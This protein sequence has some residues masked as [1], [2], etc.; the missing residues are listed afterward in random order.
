MVTSTKGR[1]PKTPPSKG[2][3]E[4]WKS[5]RKKNPTKEKVTKHERGG[6]PVGRGG[7]MGGRGRPSTTSSE[8]ESDEDDESNE[9]GERHRALV[10]T[11]TSKTTTQEELLKILREKEWTIKKL[12]AEL[13]C[14]KNKSRPNK[15]SLH[16]IMKWMG[17]E[18]NF[19]ESVNTFVRVFLFPRYKFLKN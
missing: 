6:G 11:K 1:K 9:E 15:K 3:A 4:P 8:S 13:D 2:H 14:L 10:G 12:Q 16:K 17:E 18:I 5:P 7:K 19:A